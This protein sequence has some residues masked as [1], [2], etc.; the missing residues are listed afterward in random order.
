M[1][2]PARRITSWLASPRL[3]VI[4]LLIVGVWSFLGTLVPQGR[5]TDPRVV[6]WAVENPS[7]AP[8]IS[9][10]GFHKAFSSPVLVITVMLLAAS[11]AVCSW[12]RTKVAIRRFRLLKGVSTEEAERLSARPT[13]TVDVDADGPSS[14][15]KAT[16]DALRSMGLRIDKRDGMVIASS[17]PWAVLGSPVFHW[18]LL[19][20]MIVIL[21]V[22]LTRAEGLMG[23]PEGD[24]RPLA[25]ESFGLLNRGPLYRFAQSP[26]LIRVDKVDLVYMVDG[27]DRGPA[28]TVSIV[29]PDGSVAASQVVY[30]NSPLR[31]GSLIIHPSDIGLSPGFALVSR[32]GSEGARTNVI[33]DFDEQVPATTT[34]A[35]FTLTAENAENSL[36]ASVSVPLTNEAELFVREVPNP[37]RASFV[38]LAPGGGSQIASSTLSVGEDLPLP[39]GTSLRLLG[40]GYYARLSVVD[41]P[42]VSLVYALLIVALLGV[43]VSISAGRASQWRRWSRAS[44]VARESLCGSATGGRTPYACSRPRRPCARHFPPG[45]TRMETPSDYRDHADV[46]CGHGVQL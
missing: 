14:P 26:D 34:S 21:G 16:S 45:P 13:F 24:A 10:I 32:E 27:I 30:P 3:A 18:S 8:F 17:R 7:L 15:L 2:T 12:R 31:Y 37:Q 36:E 25:A 43:S 11:T 33:V 9:A 4:L 42:S 40:V 23:V 6:A 28:P 38:V 44:L 19:L 46:G 35:A 5:V 41:D 1:V 20:L 22:S 29:R 39:D